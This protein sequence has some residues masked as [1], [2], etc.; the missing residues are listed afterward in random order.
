IVQDR[1]AA[2]PAAPAA[3]RVLPGL[4]PGGEVRLPNQWSL[5]P[6]GRQ[7][8]LGD[9]PVNLALHPEGKW[10]AVL[11]A[12]YGEHD[13][14]IIHSQ[15]H[16]PRAPCRVPVAPPFYGLCFAPD[17]KTLFASGAELEVV[18]AFA[19]DDGLLARR[20]ELRVAPAQDKFIPG[21]LG[22][23]AAGRTLFA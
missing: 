18:H 20:R 1:D 14:I 11:H 9:F 13:V 8:A 7:V 19:F 5:R 17:G 3:A 4:Q 6:A 22:V 23:D 16:R 21:G 10:L 2:R 12:G 15:G